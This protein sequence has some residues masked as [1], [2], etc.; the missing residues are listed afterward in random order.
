[1]T[2]IA[3]SILSADFGRLAQEVREVV[4]AGAKWLHVDVMDGMFVPNLTIGPKVVKAIRDAAGPDV[5]VDCHLMMEKPER[6]LQAFRDAG[7]D[8][9]TVHYEACTH[10]HRV[11]Q[12][13][14]ATGANAGVALNPHTPELVVDYI[15]GEV[16]LVLVM[17]VDPGFGGQEMIYPVL[18]K[19]AH[20]REEIED[21]ELEVI[22]QVDGG[23]NLETVPYCIKAGAHVMV[24]G[25]A[26]FGQA[27]RAKA[28]RELTEAAGGKLTP[29]TV[30]AQA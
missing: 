10:L 5:I 13:I 15:L 11:I 24:A 18:E 28:L 27:D 9:I 30:T 26:V 16:D 29:P 4:A 2:T 21:R 23:V 14:K 12:Q 25:S 22:V 8:V 19:M 20:I 3:P 17:T 1:M 7:A 6:Y